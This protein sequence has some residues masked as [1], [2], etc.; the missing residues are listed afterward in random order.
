MCSYN[1]KIKIFKAVLQ[2][3]NDSKCILNIGRKYV[4]IWLF[5]F[6]SQNES[7]LKTDISTFFS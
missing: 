7:V 1:N 6:S 2:I 5:R 3:E 4:P